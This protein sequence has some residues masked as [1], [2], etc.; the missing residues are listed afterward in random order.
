M[1]QPDYVPLMST[2]RVRP[3]SRLSSPGHWEQD[4]PAE[5]ATLRPPQGPRFGATGPDLGFGLKLAKRVVERATLAEGEHDQD[6][7]TGCFACGTRRASLFHRAPTIYDME[8]SFGLWGFLPGAPADLVAFRK[9]LFAGIAHDYARRRALVGRVPDQVVRM[10][11]RDVQA[12]LRDW[13]RWLSGD[14]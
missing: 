2:D 1:A 7:L 5:L 9:P 6:V 11:P 13:R 3:S 8:W 14:A 4:R 12:G 10:S